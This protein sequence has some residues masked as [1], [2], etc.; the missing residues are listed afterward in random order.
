MSTRIIY[1]LIQH[2]VLSRLT[3]AEKERLFFTLITNLGMADI[4][5]AAYIIESVTQDAD[6][7]VV[8]IGKQR[9]S[10]QLLT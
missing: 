8:I 6:D 2:R 5:P 4:T 9:G 7:T 3:I 10:V 1:T